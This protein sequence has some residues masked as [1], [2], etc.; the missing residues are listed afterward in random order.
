MLAGTRAYLNNAW[1]VSGK[2]EKEMLALLSKSGLK[3]HREVR[4]HAMEALGLGHRH[5]NALAA[6]YL[7][8]EWQS[9]AAAVKKAA[10]K[11]RHQR[12]RSEAS[13][14]AARYSASVMNRLNGSSL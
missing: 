8:Q 10:P 12:R 4:S 3:T 1:K 7:K 14:P 2:T 13:V 6:C 5:A 9:G 11:R